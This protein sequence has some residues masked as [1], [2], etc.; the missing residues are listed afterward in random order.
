MQRLVVTLTAV[1]LAGSAQVF[2]Q[3]LPATLATLFEDIYGPNGLVVSSD[4]V[5]LDGTTH[6]AHFNSAFQSDFRLVNIALATQLASIPL[7][8]PA[9]GFTYR[10]DDATGT[11]VRSTQSFGP[12]LTDRGE[13]IGRGRVAF[14]FSY[15]GF[16]FDHLDGVP[17]VQVP[18]VF[19]H[20]NFELGGG[21]LD[22][23]GTENVIGA[24]VNQ[25]T[26][27][28]T[29]GITDRLDVA[30]AV[31]IVRTKLSLISNATVHRIGTGT[32]NTDSL[33]PRR[34]RD[35]RARLDAPVLL[36]GGGDG[37]RRHAGAAQGDA[38]ARI[39]ARVRCGC[40]HQDADR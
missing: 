18:A 6:G 22:V 4:D 37:A 31:P 32:N 16:T 7:P 20:D 40:R 8:S 29:Y 27:A 35:R 15:Q 19:R 12:I 28:V 24:S 10:F 36:R 26:G 3:T 21:R 11:F 38:H 13:T 33:F 30:L 34:R 17:L 39:G 5:Q 25:F 14:G 2:A 9:S 23:I 1:W